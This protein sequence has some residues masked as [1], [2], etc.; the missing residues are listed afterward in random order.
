MNQKTDVIPF[1]PTAQQAA[2]EQRVER[3]DRQEEYRRTNQMS[4]LTG[5]A[6]QQASLGKAGVRSESKENEK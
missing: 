2:E 3:V 1:V 4:R 5:R 6:L